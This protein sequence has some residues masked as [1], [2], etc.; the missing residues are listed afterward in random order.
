MTLNLPYKVRATLYIITALGSPVIGYLFTIGTIGKEAV[1]LWGAEVTVV[2]LLAAF[3]TT[4]S[5]DEV[6]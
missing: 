4:P 3:N 5:I 6:E 1:A 2:G